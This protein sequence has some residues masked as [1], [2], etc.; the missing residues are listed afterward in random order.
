MAAWPNPVR[1]IVT[2]RLADIQN[3]T[4]RLFDISGKEVLVAFPE[5]ELTRI[6]LASLFDGVYLLTVS[7]GGQI[8]SRQ[9]VVKITG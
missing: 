7:K 8:V 4:L 1:D 9:R 3:T 6:N 2:V 5:T